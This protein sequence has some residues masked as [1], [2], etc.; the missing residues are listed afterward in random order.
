[1]IHR[2]IVSPVCKRPK[3]ARPSHHTSKPNAINGAEREIIVD[4][5]AKELAE[6]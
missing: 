1:M 2:F 4:N 3:S 5:Q 6:E